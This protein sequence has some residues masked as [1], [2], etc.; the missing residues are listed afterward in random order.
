M[1]AFERAAGMQYDGAGVAHGVGEILAENLDVMTGRH[2]PIDQLFIKAPFKPQACMLDPQVR[3]SSQRGASSARS[4][5]CPK[6]TCRVNT[7]AC[8]CGWPSPPMVP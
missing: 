5:G 2:Q 6:V 8:V 3:P 7:A 1:T 4:S